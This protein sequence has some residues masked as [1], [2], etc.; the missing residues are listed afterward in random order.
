[1]NDTLNYQGNYVIP[2]S[3]VSNKGDFIEH[4]GCGETEVGLHAGQLL[5]PKLKSFY[6]LL[7][8][9]SSS[10]RLKP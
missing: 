8:A 4:D 1:M 3:V 5:C 6:D 9:I 7:F 10:S 2:G